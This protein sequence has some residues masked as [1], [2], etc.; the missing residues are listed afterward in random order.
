MASLRMGL[1][2]LTRYEGMASKMID[3]KVVGRWVGAVMSERLSLPSAQSSTTKVGHVSS[4]EARNSAVT[5]CPYTRSVSIEARAYLA[6]SK[7]STLGITGS[8]TAAKDANRPM[9]CSVIEHMASPATFHKTA[10]SELN[11]VVF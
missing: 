3:S 8:K 4:R 1:N 9:L 6:S 7:L 5:P 10:F 11:F 2:S